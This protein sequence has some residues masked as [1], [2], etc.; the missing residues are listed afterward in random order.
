MANFLPEETVDEALRCFMERG[1]SVREVMAH[2]KMAKR[3]AT[4][5][6]QMLTRKGAD[7]AGRWV[8]E[9]GKRL[10]FIPHETRLTDRSPE[11]HP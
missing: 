6:Q 7:P 10:K 8:A 4:T 1:M 9:K 3:T 11:I 2:C 5:I